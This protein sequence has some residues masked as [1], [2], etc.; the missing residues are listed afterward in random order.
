MISAYEHFPDFEIIIG[1]DEAGRGPI[2]G[3]V[4][5]ASVILS[6][7]NDFFELKDSKKLTP[8]RRELLYKKITTES[9]FYDYIAIE[10]EIIDRINILQATFL[11]MNSLIEPHFK[12]SFLALVDGPYLPCKEGESDG[13]LTLKS[14]IKGDATYHCIAAASIVAKVVRD[15]IMDNFHRQYPHYDFIHNKGYPTRK[16]KEAILNHGICPIHRKSFAPVRNNF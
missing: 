8:R 7:N 14:V 4:V 13:K 2:A 3:P 5:V 1:I 11:G 12:K 10:P 6:R 16:H 15:R 9:L